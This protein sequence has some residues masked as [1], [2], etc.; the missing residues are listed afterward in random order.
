MDMRGMQVVVAGAAT[1]GAAS[2]ILLA[3]AGATVRVVDRMAQLKLVGAGI[4]LAANG[5][6]VL[7]RLGLTTLLHDATRVAGARIIDA[8]GR[9]L[10][11]PPPG[12]DVRIVTRADLQ[13]ALQEAMRATPG[14]TLTF[15]A[16]VEAASRDGLVRVRHAAS[17]QCEVLHADLVL[18]ADGVHS[19]VRGSGEFGATVKRTGIHY[20]RALSPLPPSD[21][22]EAW[23]PAGIFGMLPVMLPNG[24]GSYLYASCGTTEL[25]Q[26]IK[27]ADLETFRMI[28]RRA[29]PAGAALLDSFTAF[30]DL[31]VH[32]VI[33][34]S[35]TTWYDGR[36]VLLGD[37]AHAMAPNLGQGGNSALVDAVVLTE[38]LQA[39]PTLDHAL[40][41]YT[42]RRKPA[43]G[44][45]ADT[46]ARL[47]QISEWT[48][49][50][51]R[52]LRDRVVMPLA[53]R[54]DSSRMLRDMLQEDP[55]W[56]RGR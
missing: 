50:V 30:D 46:S 41:Q 49:P 18:G 11:A 35:C 12:T 13:A 45:V 42:A 38:C 37:A 33:R 2:A 26:A 48:H 19:R 47:G 52:W 21:A 14:I 53:G 4:A 27:S 15:D 7:E 43:V 34:V 16:T 31:L 1:A 55:A 56:L 40:A 23:T 44:R 25:A 24:G 28:W 36:L 22:V 39:A 17:D 5:Q 32:E 3:R 10:L 54:G 8:H 51:L 29:F 9:T 6:A 20:M